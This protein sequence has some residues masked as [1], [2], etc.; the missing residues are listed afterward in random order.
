M[1]LDLHAENL[2]EVLQRLVP[3]VLLDLD[4][5]EVIAFLVGDA[6]LFDFRDRP[7]G[8]RIDFSGVFQPQTGGVPLVKVGRL[9]IGKLDELVNSSGFRDAS[10]S[11]TAA[12]SPR[13]HAD[14]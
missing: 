11:A 10:A 9:G 1:A 4:G 7:D 6:R 12:R 2:G 5:G 14:G 3:A 13:A 8:L